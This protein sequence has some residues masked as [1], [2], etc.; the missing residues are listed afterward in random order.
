MRGQFLTKDFDTDD[1]SFFK[2]AVV[3]RVF[4]HCVIGQVNVDLVQLGA[5]EVV[6]FAG[7]AHVR[8]SEQIKSGV[9][10]DHCPNPQVKLATT[11][12][13]R[14]LDVL[15]HYKGC[16][17][18]LLDSRFFLFRC[19]CALLLLLVR[20][21]LIGQLLDFSVPSLEVFFTALS[22]CLCRPELGWDLHINAVV[23]PQDILEVLA[24]VEHVDS[25][26][27]IEPSWLQ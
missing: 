22:L 14:S 18:N 21:D 25:D 9:V 23:G 17:L 10:V 27:S 4:L 3:L 26:P 24:R 5:G 16:I 12:Q 13:Q 19:L 6:L 11:E 7:C 8:L 2:L 20:G 15:L 1:V